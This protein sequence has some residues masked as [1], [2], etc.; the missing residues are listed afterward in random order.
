MKKYTL[1]DSAKS[2]AYSLYLQMLPSS[3]FTG[4]F[5]CYSKLP[6]IAG[7]AYSNPSW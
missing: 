4:T 7:L 1:T 6:F 5:H 3:N 2:V